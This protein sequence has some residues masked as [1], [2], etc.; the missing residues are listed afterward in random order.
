M[1]ASTWRWHTAPVH[2]TEAKPRCTADQESKG[3]KA[4]RAIP[5]TEALTLQIVSAL[6]ANASTITLCNN[7]AA[8]VAAAAY[9]KLLLDA[10]ATLL[11]A[12]A[13]ICF[14]KMFFCASLP[15]QVRT[16]NSWVLLCILLPKN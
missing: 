15:M 2:A 10:T 6:A 9:G 16:W 4:P 1:H 5:A 13:Q 7:A 8:D 12:A 11:A 3:K 14:S